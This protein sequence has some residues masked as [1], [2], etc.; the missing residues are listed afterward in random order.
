MKKKIAIA[1]AGA[2]VAFAALAQLTTE[3]HIQVKNLDRDQIQG[4]LS[5]IGV[6][7]VPADKC[8]TIRINCHSGTATVLARP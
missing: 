1:A 4:V 6:T 7:N 2:L 3:L 8:L 5:A